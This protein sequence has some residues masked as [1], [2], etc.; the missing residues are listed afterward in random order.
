MVRSGQAWEGG[1]GC[2]FAGDAGM[3]G[4]GERV[5]TE[6]SRSQV[7]VHG[8]AVCLAPTAIL[9]TATYRD[10]FLREAGPRKGRMSLGGSHDDDNDRDDDSSY[11]LS[12]RLLSIRHCAQNLSCIISFKVPSNLRGGTVLFLPHQRRKTEAQ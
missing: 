1:R 3:G 5:R 7:R 12:E 4:G 10:C 2:E 8:A 11:S 6:K 9:H